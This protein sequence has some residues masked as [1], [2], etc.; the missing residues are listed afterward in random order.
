MF[1]DVELSP[2]PRKMGMG[3]LAGSPGFLSFY[4]LAALSV[5]YFSG[6]VLLVFGKDVAYRWGR[7]TGI[8]RLFNGVVTGLLWVAAIGLPAIL[9]YGNFRHIRDSNGSAVSQFANEMAKSLP[10]MP[11]VVLADDPARLYLAMGASQRLG[12]PDQYTFIESRSLV[13]R[14]YLRYLA[15]RYPAFRKEVEDRTPARGDHRPANRRSP[16]A[17]CPAAAGLLFASQFRQ[18]L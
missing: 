12:L 5:G 7:A 8:L 13:H 3:V 15:D 4:Y 18:L 16:V 1:F 9:F 10:P 17:S 6:Y 14:E 11:A 2:S